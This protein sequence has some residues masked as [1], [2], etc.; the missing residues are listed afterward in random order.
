MNKKENLE[1]KPYIWLIFWWIIAITPLMAGWKWTII[2]LILCALLLY[3]TIKRVKNNRAYNK[4]NN[5]K[6]F[7]NFWECFW[8]GIWFIVVW[9]IAIN[10]EEYIKP[11]LF[12][13]SWWIII[14]LI[15]W[16]CLWVFL[17]IIFI[18]RIIKV[19]KLPWQIEELN[20]KLDKIEKQD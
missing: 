18:K 9:A 3:P 4:K 13:E 5:I 16:S 12:A 17:I 20:K 10:R 1:Y 15:L 14:L 11:R 7:E 19:I 8:S 2:S 6:V